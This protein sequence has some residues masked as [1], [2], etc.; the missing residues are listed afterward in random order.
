MLTIGPLNES[1]PS[2]GG[3]DVAFAVPRAGAISVEVFDVTGR[4]VSTLASGERAPG[5]YQA[6]WEGGA[7]GRPAASGIYFVRLRA[8]EVQMVRRLVLAR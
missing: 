2:F 7:S 6:R 4:L 8:A 3:A 1:N 5:R